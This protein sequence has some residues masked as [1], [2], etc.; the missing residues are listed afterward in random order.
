MVSEVDID[1]IIVYGVNQQDFSGCEMLVFNVFCMINCGVLLFKLLNE[2]IGLEYVLII[3]IYLVM[4]DQLVID[5]Y[6]YEDLC[7][8]CLVF[9]LVILVFIGLV[10]GIECLLLEFVGCIQ[11][12]VICVFMVNVLV[13]DI[14][15]QI[16][17]DIFVVEINWV[18]CEVV[19]S[20]LLCGLLVYIELLYVSCDFNYDFYL[21]IVD[22]SQICVFGFCL[23]NLLVWFDN[24]W[25]FVN[26]M[27]DVVGYYLCVV[28]FD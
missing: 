24:E 10:C 23:V 25:G 5:V 11:V 18:F 20:G 13:L 28:V 6:Y 27:F 4:N 8:I 2:V 19:E 26:C 12:K 21:V 3:I 14:I 17:C 7:C 15:L 16:F 9:Q 1:V 22:G